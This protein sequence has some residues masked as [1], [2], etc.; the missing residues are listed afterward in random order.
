MIKLTFKEVAKQF[1]VKIGQ[2]KME[3]F[4]ITFK[5]YFSV[6]SF[7]T[8]LCTYV[9]TG[10]L[11]MNRML[12]LGSNVRSRHHNNKSKTSSVLNI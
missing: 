11:E 4:T 1:R 2:K 6:F 10:Q 7:F 12:S 5:P 8:L 3:S 9:S